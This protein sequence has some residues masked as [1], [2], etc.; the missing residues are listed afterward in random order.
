MARANPSRLR[1]LPAA[2]EITRLRPIDTRETVYGVTLDCVYVELVSGLCFTSLQGWG[3]SAEFRG[4][5]PL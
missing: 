2:A 3:S 5:W 4:F 1:L